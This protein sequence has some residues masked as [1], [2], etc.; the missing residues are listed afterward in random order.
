[1]IFDSNCNLLL[2]A[3]LQRL[4][5]CKI[6]KT[7]WLPFTY[8]IDAEID[9][10][11]AWGGRKVDEKSNPFTYCLKGKDIESSE[12]L[13]RQV[14]E[15]IKKRHNLNNN[16]FDDEYF[17]SDQYPWLG[18]GKISDRQV[19]LQNELG[20]D[21]STLLSNNHNDQ[22][23]KLEIRRL[24]KI[25]ISLQ[26]HG[27]NKNMLRYTPMRA[28]LALM[29]D[30]FFFLI[31]HGEHR[32]SCLPHFDTKIATLWVRHSDILRVDKN[33]AEMVSWFNSVY[34]GNLIGPPL[35]NV[36]GYFFV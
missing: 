29:D 18:K 5:N 32:I 12:K 26:R 4:S 8:I 25:F 22:L 14:V 11:R 36:Y 31:R 13:Y 30:K 10:I 1:M 35:T 2:T 15:K 19:T 28:T 21:K 3:T 6:Y 7:K 34:E 24:I 16:S 20:M 33:N 17:L 9:T 23:I 27:Y